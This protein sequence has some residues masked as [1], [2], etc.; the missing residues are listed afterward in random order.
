MTKTINKIELLA[1][2]ADDYM[3]DIQISYFQDTLKQQ[4]FEIL[5]SMNSSKEELRVS[6]K[7]SDMSDVAT[8]YELQQLALKRVDRER[9]LLN[10]INKTLASIRNGEY[11]YC[12]ATGEEIGLKRMIARPTATMTIGAKERQEF[13]EKTIGAA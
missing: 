5:E 6:E 7:S 9:K 12:E 3:N 4:R 8:V 13:K 11:G 2:P 1:M 10:K